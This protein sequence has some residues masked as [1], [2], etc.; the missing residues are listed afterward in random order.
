M[1]VKKFIN[2]IFTSNTYLISEAGYNWVWLIDVGDIDGVLIYISKDIL[3][4]G[5]FITH[6]HFDHIYGIN[7][8]ID[9]FPD[10]IVCTSEVGMEGLFSDKLNLSYY[11]EDPIVF[12]GS[13]VQILHEAD[14]IELFEDWFL[15]TL[16]TPG[17]N[18]G[19]LTY[20]IANY[21]FTG[22][23]YIP[24][25]EVVTKLKGGDRE[26]SNR[27]LQKILSNIDENTIICPGH[28]GMKLRT[29]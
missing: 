26:A 29:T 8:L 28:G 5:V 22:D 27:S 6:T 7:Q 24:D 12:T 16:E 21:L 10:C 2:S 9:S 1:R 4:R 18:W 14:K 17:H 3:V 11:H 15:E 25:I 20:K 23:A 19:Y 13:N